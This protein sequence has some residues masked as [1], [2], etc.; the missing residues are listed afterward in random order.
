M[1]SQANILRETIARLIAKNG[2]E[3]SYVKALKEQL[4][5]LENPNEDQP[6]RLMLST[7]KGKSKE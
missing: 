2:G 4:H 3:T 6:E 1:P 7:H 5:G